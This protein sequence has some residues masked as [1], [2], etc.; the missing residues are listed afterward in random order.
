[1]SGLACICVGFFSL[2]GTNHSEDYSGDSVRVVV[3]TEVQVSQSERLQV[4][5]GEIGVL[6]ILGA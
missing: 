3:E 4:W 1:M 2:E 5:A 6:H